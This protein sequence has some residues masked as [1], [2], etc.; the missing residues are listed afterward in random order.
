[1]ANKN[2]KFNSWIKQKPVEKKKQK[3]QLYKSC[4]IAGGSCKSSPLFRANDSERAAVKS[5]WLVNAK[6]MAL[7][8]SISI[9]RNK[10][11][12]HNTK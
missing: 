3:K 2:K 7:Y 8:S 5:N 12:K 10:R 1:M 9:I 4:L 11:M 6:Q